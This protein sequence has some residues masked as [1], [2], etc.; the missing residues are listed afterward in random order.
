[1]FYRHSNHILFVKQKAQ[2]KLLH[3]SNIPLK[4]FFDLISG[5]GQLTVKIRGP[6]G[7]FRVEMQREHLQDRTIICRYNPSEPGDYLISVKWS[8]EHVYGSP[9]HTHIF[10]RQ[11]ELDRFIHEQNAYRLAQ[12]QWRD[13]V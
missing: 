3:L 9:F 10:E 6:K 1:V 2:V 5:A 13:E 8:D 7:A 11:E 4:D 12:H